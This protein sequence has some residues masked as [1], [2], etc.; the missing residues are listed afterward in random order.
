MKRFK[1]HFMGILILVGVSFA[2]YAFDYKSIYDYD[3]DPQDP[4][5]LIYFYNDSKSIEESICRMQK[6]I[7]FIYANFDCND[8]IDLVELGYDLDSVLRLMQIHVY[9]LKRQL[10]LEN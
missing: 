10:E 4:T 9:G 3:D 2:L 8:E 1:T 6:L 5:E 7:D